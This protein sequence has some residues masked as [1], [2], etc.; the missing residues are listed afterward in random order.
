M[1]H[2]VQRQQWSNVTRYLLSQ[3]TRLVRSIDY[4]LKNSEQVKRHILLNFVTIHIH[5]SQPP[6][7]KNPHHPHPLRRSMSDAPSSDSGGD[8]P[9]QSST[10]RTAVTVKANTKLGH[11]CPFTPAQKHD[12]EALFPAYSH[13]L[14]GR[15]VGSR[16]RDPGMHERA[17]L[18][19]NGWENFWA[20]HKH[21]LL[22]MEIRIKGEFRVPREDEWKSV[23]T[24]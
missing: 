11:P 8:A 18:I 23:R 20:K 17:R 22:R 7:P 1:A 12:I 9:H 14:D 16:A 3:T 5:R 10:G 13:L 21:N 4:D 24:S 2:R 15:A 19:A 6:P